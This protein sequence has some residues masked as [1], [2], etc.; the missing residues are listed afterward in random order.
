MGEKTIYQKK[1][2]AAKKRKLAAWKKPIG[3]PYV[4]LQRHFK[5]VLTQLLK[6]SNYVD[7]EHRNDLQTILQFL[8]N[9]KLP[10]SRACHINFKKR[11]L[12]YLT[13][14][15]NK[16]F[17]TKLADLLPTRVYWADIDQLHEEHQYNK[18]P[19]QILDIVQNEEGEK[20]IY[21]VRLYGRAYL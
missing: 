3:N 19:I 12:V 6:E 9:N 4:R 11:M 1:I 13:K 15:L 21:Y 14:S 2:E 5:E 7:A 17:N 18:Q 20:I 16:Q 8:A 10:L